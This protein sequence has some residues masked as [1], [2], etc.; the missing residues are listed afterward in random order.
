MKSLPSWPS[1]E[2]GFNART[3]HR[4]I[5]AAFFL[6][7]L[8]GQWGEGFELWSETSRPLST[9]V[10]EGET[11]GLEASHGKLSIPRWDSG[12]ERNV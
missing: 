12:T 11:N 3:T 6:C 1:L 2:P 7:L 5:A 8:G 4:S 10:N 9:D